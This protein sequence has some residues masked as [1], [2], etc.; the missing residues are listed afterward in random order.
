[1]NSPSISR[2]LIVFVF[3][4]VVYISVADLGG[5]IPGVPWNPLLAGTD[6]VL[7]GTPLLRLLH[8][9]EALIKR[10]LKQVD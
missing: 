10:L 4:A 1:M 2:N 7:Y 6:F 3:F 9:A 8:V 5:E